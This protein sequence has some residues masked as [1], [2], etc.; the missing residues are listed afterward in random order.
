MS[1]LTESIKKLTEA[2][3]ILNE[4]GKELENTSLK[5]EKKRGYQLESIQ[6]RNVNNFKNYLYK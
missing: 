5:I 4:T 6:D 2:C 1:G 3:N